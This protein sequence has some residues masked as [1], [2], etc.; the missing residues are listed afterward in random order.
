MLHNLYETIVI[1]SPETQEEEYT[2]IRERLSGIIEQYEGQV[3]RFKDWGHRKL[4]YPIQGHARGR[5]LYYRYV[6][7]PDCVL[8]L[9]R[10]IRIEGEAVRFLTVRLEAGVNVE[11]YQVEEEEPTGEEGE[12]D[13]DSTSSSTGST[14]SEDSD[15]TTS[16]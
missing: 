8:E 1:L 7:L 11:D 14:D 10:I 13:D 6:S 3:T 2:R 15:D 4:A 12:S 16:D 5:Y 9:E